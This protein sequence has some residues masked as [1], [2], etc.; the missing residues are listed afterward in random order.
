MGLEQQLISYREK[1]LAKRM[2][3]L[4]VLYEQS[5]CYYDKSDEE[6]S[7][8]IVDVARLYSKCYVSHKQAEVVGML[9]ARASLQNYQPLFSTSYSLV[10]NH[11]DKLLFL[12][13]PSR[14]LISNIL[15]LDIK[16]PSFCVGKPNQVSHHSKFL[17]AL[18]DP[19]CVAIFGLNRPII[20]TNDGQHLTCLHNDGVWQHIYG[21]F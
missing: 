16:H 17:H 19:R 20:H 21:L 3:K 5:Q 7:G 4:S 10:C 6:R 2:V 15:M 9:Q 12:K 1:A 8:R 11:S 13:C 18:L 14:C